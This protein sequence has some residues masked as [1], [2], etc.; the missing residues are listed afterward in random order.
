MVLDQLVSLVRLDPRD[1]RDKLVPL[2]TLVSKEL[3]VLKD[4]LVAQVFQVCRV[5]VELLEAQDSLD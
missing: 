5:Q 4:F 2:A 1:S 3:Q